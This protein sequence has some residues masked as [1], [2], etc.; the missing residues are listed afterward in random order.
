MPT[1][2]FQYYDNNGRFHTGSPHVAENVGILPSNNKWPTPFV[3][4]HGNI[5]QY[6]NTKTMFLRSTPQYQSFFYRY[7]LRSHIGVNLYNYSPNKMCIDHCSVV[8]LA[9]VL[10][11]QYLVKTCSFLTHR[12]QYHL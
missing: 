9:H 7:R 1:H 6:S 2:F 4:V 11:V 10:K 5:F 12:P 8:L 3:Q